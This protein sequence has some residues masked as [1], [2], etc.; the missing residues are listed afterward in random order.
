MYPFPLFVSEDLFLFQCISRAR[1]YLFIIFVENFPL[2]VLYVDGMLGN[3]TMVVIDNLIQLMVENMEEPIPHVPG[4]GN[5]W[6]EIAVMRL[7]SCMIRGA[8]LPSTLQDRDLDWE[9]VLSLV[10]AQ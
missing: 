6:I 4:L 3:K 10:L 2:F 5:G 8:L 9:F 1:V 7:Y